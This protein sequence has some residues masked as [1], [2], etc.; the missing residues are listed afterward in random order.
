M[1]TCQ[2]LPSPNSSLRSRKPPSSPGERQELLRGLPGQERCGGTVNPA[3]HS[4]LPCLKGHGLVLHMQMHSLG[5]SWRI[6]QRWHMPRGFG[7]CSFQVS[8][9]R[10]VRWPGCPGASI[11]FPALSGTSRI[12][13][14][15]TSVSVQLLMKLSSTIT[16]GHKALAAGEKNRMKHLEDVESLAQRGWERVSLFIDSSTQHLLHTPQAART[17]GGQHLGLGVPAGTLL[18]LVCGCARSLSPKIATRGKQA[19]CKAIT[20]GQERGSC[21]RVVGVVEVPG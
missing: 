7:Q 5:S 3:P 10:V 21:A 11:Q 17:A 20:G 13:P 19:A 18:V 16:R 15:T 14:L 6:T 2:W 1:V 8:W 9:M 12:E 4:I